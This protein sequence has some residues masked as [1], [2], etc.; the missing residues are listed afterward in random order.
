MKTS[1]A[2]DVVANLQNTSAEVFKTISKSF[3]V[4]YSEAEIAALI[5]LE[6]RKRGIVDFW[7]DVPIIVLIGTE[8]FISGANA[9][10]ATKSPSVDAVLKDGS[11]IYVDVH[12]QDNQTKIWGDWNT[13][14]VFHPRVGIDDEQVAF[15]EE[16]REIHRKGIAQLTPTMT[17]A[18]VINYYF[19]AYKEGGI[20]PIIG[21]KPDVGHTVHAGVKVDAKR[22]LLCEENT[23]PI[24]E[25][26]YAV[27]PAGYR[28]K[29]SGE[30]VVVG[31]F[32]E[33]VYIPKLGNA[34]L[35]GSKELLAL[36]I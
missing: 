7:Y 8:R 35:L 5:K 16:I 9:D 22:L 33:C 29:K 25:H 11:I 13:M 28:P 17:G 30:G 23:T 15:L 6:F 31:R 36:T 19:T 20:M 1:N 21:N 3:E 27:E 4:G 32:E 18:D 12:P 26:I 14:A 10:Y 2:L 34:I 24:G